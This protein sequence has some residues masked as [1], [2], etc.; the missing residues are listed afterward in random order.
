[1]SQQDFNV[2]L[3]PI[4]RPQAEEQEPLVFHAPPIVDLNKPVLQ[5]INPVVD[6]IKA[7]FYWAIFI[8]Y[9]YI[10]AL[11]ILYFFTE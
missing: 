10:H 11:G 8:I 4:V 6:F 7:C 9:I 1:M 3:Y 2:G 5:I